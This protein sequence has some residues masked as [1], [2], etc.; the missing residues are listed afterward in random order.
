MPAEESDVPVQIL[1]SVSKRR[2][3]HAVD[4]N[5]TKRLIREAYRLNKHL[6]D[7]LISAGQHI[8]IAFI[9]MSDQRCDFATVEARMKSLLQR[10]AE[11][12]YSQKT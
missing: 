1:I 11:T 7:N 4:R 8:D 6:L 10:I 2:F 9:W 5:R 12:L 3:K